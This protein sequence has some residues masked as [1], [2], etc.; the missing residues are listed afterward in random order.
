[1]VR[2]YSSRATWGFP[3]GKIAKEELPADCAAREVLEEVGFDIGPCLQEG[4]FL[5]IDE[6][7]QPVRLYLIPNISEETSFAPQTRGEIGDIRW[8]RIADILKSNKTGD[9]SDRYFNVLPFVNML[10]AWIRK[11]KEPL[12]AKAL[13][14]PSRPLPPKVQRVGSAPQL[15]RKEQESTDPQTVSHLKEIRAALG[16]LASFTIDLDRLI[17]VFRAN[18]KID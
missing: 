14:R 12:N 9:T 13:P 4:E 1:M 16:P 6:G 11:R 2:G 7:K 17:K 18:Y 10:R 3:K 15:K 5:Q 8:H